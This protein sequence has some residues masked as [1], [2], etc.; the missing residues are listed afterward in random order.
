MVSVGVWWC[1]SGPQW[2][3]MLFC[4]Y[5]LVLKGKRGIGERWMLTFCWCLMMNVAVGWCFRALCAGVLFLC[6][7]LMVSDGV[8]WCLDGCWLLTGVNWSLVVN[9]GLT[10]ADNQTTERAARSRRFWLE[11]LQLGG[12]IKKLTTI[13][14]RNTTETWR[15]LWWYFVQTDGE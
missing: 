4:W 7:G 3:F 9:A 2:R 14:Q 10:C 12:L 6:W 13:S 5:M 8:W 1:F 15:F 11:A